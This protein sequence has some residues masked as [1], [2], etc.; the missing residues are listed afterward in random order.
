MMQKELL[1]SLPGVGEIVLLAINESISQPKPIH[2]RYSYDWKLLRSTVPPA[3]A[4]GR[5]I[6]GILELLLAFVW[7]QAVKL[8]LTAGGYL[9]AHKGFQV[10]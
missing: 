5:N 4:Q 3:Y 1:E 10:K 7:L 2:R 6:S 8:A 9:G